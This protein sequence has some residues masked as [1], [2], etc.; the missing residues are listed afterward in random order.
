MKTRTELSD[1][2][3]AFVEAL[4]GKGADGKAMA[5]GRAYERAGYRARGASADSLASKMLRK[6]KVAAQIKRRRRE[7][8]EA[9]Q[10]EKW[11]LVDWLSRALLT[12]IG[13]IDADSDLAQEVTEESVGEEIL[14]TKTKVVGKIEAG[15]L[16]ATLLNWT[17]PE[18]HEVKFEIVIGGHADA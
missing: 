10:I 6:D 5:A 9:S 2:E 14:R 18:K 11:Q 17:E 13:E 16:L 15:K 12:P 7:I 8:A 3:I 4:L 1:R